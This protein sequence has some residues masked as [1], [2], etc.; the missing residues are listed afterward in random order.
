MPFGHFMEAETDLPQGI[1]QAI[2]FRWKHKCSE[3]ARSWVRGHGYQHRKTVHLGSDTPAH[4]SMPGV[5]RVAALLY[6][7]FGRCQLS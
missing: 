3:P 1:E 6:R 5:H 7:W 2:T 4:E